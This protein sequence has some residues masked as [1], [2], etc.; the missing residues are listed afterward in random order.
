MRR[1]IAS[2]AALVLGL[3]VSESA[4]ANKGVPLA[5]SASPG[6]VAGILLALIIEVI[7]W[8]R[9]NKIK[10]TNNIKDIAIIYLGAFI[11]YEMFIFIW[12]KAT[13]N[14]FGEIFWFSW[15][16]NRGMPAG[17]IWIEFITVISII[18][19]PLFSG[20][21]LFSWI[22]GG[23]NRKIINIFYDKK[24]YL[25]LIYIVLMA[26]FLIPETR[27]FVPVVEAER[28]KIRSIE[29]IEIPVPVNAITRILG[30]EGDPTSCEVIPGGTNIGRYIYKKVTDEKEKEK[31]QEF[32]KRFEKGPIIIEDKAE[33]DL[34]NKIFY[35]SLIEKIDV[36]SLGSKK[37]A[38]AQMMLTGDTY[39]DNVSLV[40]TNGKTILK[41]EIWKIESNM[42]PPACICYRLCLIE[43]LND[44][45]DK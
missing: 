39:I 11:F 22:R 7:V 37:Y 35:S 23:R 30:F 21:I 17:Y 25:L 1:K 44:R 34:L 20:I 36:H 6:L 31:L 12:V 16:R 24:Y 19:I 32:F 18:I 10:R 28:V 4:F 42:P 38:L 9:R 29:E 41:Y 26:W 40:K 13:N 33:Y 14:D 15:V 45:A 43:I 2:R 8:A 3:G 27:Y 5:Y